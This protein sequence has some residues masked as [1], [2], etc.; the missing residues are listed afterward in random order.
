MKLVKFTLESVLQI[1]THVMLH[2][3]LIDRFEIR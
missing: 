2:Q 1:S 3:I